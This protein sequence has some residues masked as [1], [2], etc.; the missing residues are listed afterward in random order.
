MTGFE[1]YTEN[2]QSQ[3]DS[4]GTKCDHRKRSCKKKLKK[5]TESGFIILV[6]YT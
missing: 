5:Y 4:K 6:I 2:T 1:Q 3:P